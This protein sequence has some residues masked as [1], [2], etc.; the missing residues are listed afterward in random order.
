MPDPQSRTPDSQPTVIFL[1]ACT[2]DL[3]A[4]QPLKELL[5]MLREE[6]GTDVERWT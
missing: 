4:A 5:D 3:V 1:I 2:E 6:F